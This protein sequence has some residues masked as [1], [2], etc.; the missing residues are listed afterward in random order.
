M[1]TTSYRAVQASK[2]G[3]LE[4]V[5]REPTAPPPGKVRIRVEA[6]EFRDEK[7]AKCVSRKTEEFCPACS[8][9]TLSTG[10]DA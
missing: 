3:C 5:E 2:P 10:R 7:S 1:T 9:A 4:V 8:L 6:C